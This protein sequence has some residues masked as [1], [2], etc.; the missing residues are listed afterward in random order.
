MTFYGVKKHPHLNH[1]WNNHENS[2]VYTTRSVCSPLDDGISLLPIKVRCFCPTA[3]WWCISGKVH[4]RLWA[5]EM[6]TQSTHIIYTGPQIRHLSY[7]RKWL[8]FIYFTW[9]CS[10]FLHNIYL[11]NWVNYVK[12]NANKIV[13]SRLR[14]IHIYINEYIYS[15]KNCYINWEFIIYLDLMNHIVISDFVYFVIMSITYTWR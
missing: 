12:V 10:I 7:P 6:M 3:L 8:W 13:Y 2:R 4:I 15:K 14:H 11:W 9:N 1:P 5:C